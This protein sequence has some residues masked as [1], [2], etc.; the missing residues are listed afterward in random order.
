MNW[1][2]LVLL[3][4]ILLC[5]IKGFRYGLVRQAIRLVGFLLAFFLTLRWSSI[6]VYL[7]KEVIPLE[8]ILERML[9][10]FPAAALLADLIIQVIGFI[11]LFIIIGSIINILGSKLSIINRIPVVGFFNRVIGGLVGLIKGV[12]MVLLIIALLSIVPTPFW[13]NSLQDSAV[14]N[15]VLIYL[16]I[17]I[18]VLIDLLRE[19]LDFI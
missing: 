14:A 3:L 6:F 5:V 13:K 10:E 9:K 1:L 2:D 15:Y 16:N 19:N 18:D 7:I 4:V 8:P 11:I 12:I 17:F